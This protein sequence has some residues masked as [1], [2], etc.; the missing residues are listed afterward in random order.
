M[1]NVIHRMSDIFERG[2]FN[3]ASRPIKSSLQIVDQDLKTLNSNVY[4]LLSAEH[5]VLALV[6]KYYVCNVDHYEE[7]FHY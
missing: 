2:T 1:E 7:N 3:L 4:K 5:S 6:A